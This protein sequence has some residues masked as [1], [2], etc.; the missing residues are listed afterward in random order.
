MMRH[1]A[2][3][4]ALPADGH[5]LYVRHGAN[6]WRPDA[7]PA[8]GGGWVEEVEPTWL[9]DDRSFYAARSPAAQGKLSPPCATVDVSCIMPTANRRRFLPAAIDGF[10]AQRGVLA[11][12]IIVD[13]GDDPVDDLVPDNPRVRYLRLDRTATIGEKRNLAIQAALGEVIV[14]LDD[15]DWSH[16]E[17]LRIQRDALAVGDIDVCGLDRMLWWNPTL[18]VAWR[19]TCPPVRRPWVAGNTLAY[20]R[21]TWRRG[22]FPAHSLGEDTAFVWGRADRRV[23][24]LGDERLVVGTLHEGN[25]S[26]KHMTAAQW[27]PVGPG[28]VHAL[29]AASARS[30]GA[31]S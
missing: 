15:D 16:P 1:G 11:E 26:V 21:S 2:R 31:R 9:A 6:T 29:I 14:H 12:L 22:G 4:V 7:E 13:D 10:L 20:T 19:Y 3:L 30:V 24:A 17:R 5:Y 25:T 23:R 28:E 18:G 27:S 8:P